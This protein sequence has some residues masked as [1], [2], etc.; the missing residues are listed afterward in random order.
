MTVILRAGG[1]ARV[2]AMKDQDISSDK[3]EKSIKKFLAILLV[4]LIVMMN[5]IHKLNYFLNR[6]ALRIPKYY[7]IL[8]NKEY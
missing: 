1:I 8:H 2:T 7:K 4:A 3:V 6:N 5:M